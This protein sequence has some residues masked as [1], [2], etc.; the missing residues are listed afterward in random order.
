[1]KSFGTLWSVGSASKIAERDN[2]DSLQQSILEN[3]CEK[4]HFEFTTYPG[5][6]IY[7]IHFEFDDFEINRTLC[8]RIKEDLAIS[9]QSCEFR[10]D[11]TIP[12][13]PNW[14]FVTRTVKLIGDIDDDFPKVLT[15][16]RHFVE[17]V[18][19]S[20]DIVYGEAMVKFFLHQLE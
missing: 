9:R 6:I 18:C 3:Y 4:V 17:F 19:H 10:E 2:L 5:E 13:K 14:I 16:G 12:K 15:H 7:G 11:N 8:E 1:M 20:Y